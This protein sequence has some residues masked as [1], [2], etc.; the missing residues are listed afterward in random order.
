MPDLSTIYDYMRL[1]CLL[2][3]QQASRHASGLERRTFVTA[4][5][6]ILAIGG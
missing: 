2:D 6:F 3:Q 4:A 1:C 5:M